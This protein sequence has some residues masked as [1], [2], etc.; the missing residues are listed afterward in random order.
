MQVMASS[1]PRRPPRRRRRRRRTVLGPA[2]MAPPPRPMRPSCG[3]WWGSWRRPC[4]STRTWRARCGSKA[5][6]CCC[7]RSSA[8]AGDSRGTRRHNEHQLIACHHHNIDSVLGAQ[9]SFLYKYYVRIQQLGRLFAADIRERVDGLDHAPRQPAAA[10][11]E[12]AV[13][14]GAAALIASSASRRCASLRILS[15]FLLPRA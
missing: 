13:E 4:M 11:G 14:F 8:A 12:A 10:G 1:S 2:R 5:C 7:R 6:S 9:V 15:L 3:G